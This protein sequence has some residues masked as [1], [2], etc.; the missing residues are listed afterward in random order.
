MY[1]NCLIV[2]LISLCVAHHS[3]FWLLAFREALVLLE[4]TLASSE[5]L[6]DIKNGKCL[7]MWRLITVVSSG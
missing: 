1:C 5:P 4:T 3:Y 2:W 6:L 7:Y